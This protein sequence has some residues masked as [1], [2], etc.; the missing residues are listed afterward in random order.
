MVIED[1]HTYDQIEEAGKGF[2]RRKACWAEA[3]PWDFEQGLQHRELKP[4][5][6]DW[7]EPNTN[8]WLVVCYAKEKVPVTCAN[9]R[10]AFAAKRAE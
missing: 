2:K 8:F 7:V 1:S 9:I 6:I 4:A 3:E 10:D 5:P